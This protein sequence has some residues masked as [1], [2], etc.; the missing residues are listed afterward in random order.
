MQLFAL[1]LATALPS[2]VTEASSVL[3]NPIAAVSV[4]EN[5]SIH[6]SYSRIH[7]LSTFVLTF[8]IND[9]H[10]RVNLEPNHDILGHQT[11]V[12]HLH[13]DGTTSHSS[14]LRRLDHKIFK[15]TAW[16]RHGEGRHRWL[17]AGW[18]RVLVI[19]DGRTPLFEGTFAVDGD[20]YHVQ[21]FRNY[22]RTKHRLDPQVQALQLQGMVVWRDSDVL[23]PMEDAQQDFRRGLDGKEESSCSSDE[24]S[25]NSNTKHLV[26]AATTNK[27]GNIFARDTA[28]NEILVSKSLPARQTNGGRIGAAFVNNIGSKAGCPS[29]RMVA[30][31]GIA[32]DCTYTRDFDSVEGAKQ[33][34]IQMVN[35]ASALWEDTFNIAF[36][37]ANLTISNATCPD[38]PSQELPWNRD[39]SSRFDANQRLSSFTAWRIRQRD[40]NSHW[41]LLTACK[42]GSTIGV[43]WLGQACVNDNV[44]SNS[45]IAEDAELNNGGK[46]ET[47]SGANLVVRTAGSS[48]WQVFAHE[49]GHTFGAVHDCTSQTCSSFI[50]S[51]EASQHCCPASVDSCASNDAYV[52]NPA[53]QHGIQSFSLCSIGNVCS[54]IGRRSVKT[55]C[56]RPSGITQDDSSWAERHKALVIAVPSALGFAIILASVYLCFWRLR[57]RNGER[58][59]SRKVS[60]DKSQANQAEGSVE[61]Q[62]SA[63]D[64]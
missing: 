52:M 6:T 21:L 59:L 42:T 34:I 56:L 13:F 54:V 45:T 32:T 23:P 28:K 60:P 43:S 17:S 38:S 5:S 12:R 16:I 1:F 53:S 61:E 14:E 50:S 64:Y 19:R 57:H 18:A 8:N 55:S 10:I 62:H 4:V 37:L 41:T 9:Q 11:H 46:E 24:L 2:L 15:G 48:E 35:T 22:L 39:C 47:V 58:E 31:I 44:D 29:K 63:P 26:Y 33:N 36:A 7:A 30:S 40:N 27:S 51:V 25:F 49:T 20:Q 3:R